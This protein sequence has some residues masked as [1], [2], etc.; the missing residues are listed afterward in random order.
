MKKKYTKPQIH[1]T[2]FELSQDISAGCELITNYAENACAIYMNEPGWSETIY[3][4]SICDMTPADKSDTPCYHA[5]SDSYNV[6][7]S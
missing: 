2:S 1:F 3:G 7:S 5:P 6:Y 4:D